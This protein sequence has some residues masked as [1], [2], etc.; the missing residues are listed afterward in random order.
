MHLN[1]LLA[2]FTARHWRVR[3]PIMDYYTAFHPELD[4]LITEFEQALPND[5][6][7]R[8]EEAKRQWAARHPPTMH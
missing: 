7:E 3:A 1:K 6:R 4:R 5:L 8:Y 2:H